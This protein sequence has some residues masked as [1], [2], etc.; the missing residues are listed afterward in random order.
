MLQVV[1]DLSEPEAPVKTNLELV[2]E[3]PPATFGMSSNCTKIDIGVL[4]GTANVFVHLENN[5]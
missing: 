5:L 3:A 2:H 4:A 1:N